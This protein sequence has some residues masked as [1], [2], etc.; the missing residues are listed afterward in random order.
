MAEITVNGKQWHYE[1]KSFYNE[2]E[3]ILN[4]EDAK[5]LL[6][7]IKKVFDKH[8]LKFLLNYGTLLGAVRE[9]NFIGHD[10]DMDIAIFEKDRELLISLIPELDDLGIIFCRHSKYLI[11]SFYYKGAMCDVDIIC[12]ARWPLSYRYYCT[13]GLYHPKFYVNKSQKLLFMG[14]EYDVPLNPERYITYLYGKNWRI[15]QKGKSAR[16]QSKA[17]IHINAYRFVKRCISYIKRHFFGI[18]CK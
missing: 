7:N 13:L 14:E 15:P 5:Y 18:N 4:K 9:G 3:V 8:G 2:G 17:L 10:Y 11:F 16:V 6:H 1:A 12:N